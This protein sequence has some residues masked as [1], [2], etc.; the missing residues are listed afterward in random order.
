MS[1][2]LSFLGFGDNQ[3][4]ADQKKSFKQNMEKTYSKISKALKTKKN[5]KHVE[6]FLKHI[7]SK[8]IV[9]TK[10]E[11]AK[12]DFQDFLQ[13][14]VYK[15][16]S[17]F[18]SALS[19]RGSKILVEVTRNE[20]HRFLSNQEI[21]DRFE[22]ALEDMNKPPKKFLPSFDA[23]MKMA[24]ENSLQERVPKLN[25]KEADLPTGIMNTGNSC[26]SSAMLQVLFNYPDFVKAI[27]GF[28]YD[29]IKSVKTHVKPIK[30]LEDSV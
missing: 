6:T 23:Q 24:M 29:E 27:C 7:K 30:I 22:K 5:K 21:K 2:F 3:E 28:R 12:E 4:K 26:Y 16:Y 9:Y 13:K 14:P 25:K 18:L 20:K 8:G 19:K 11:P 15:K 1:D 10:M 17:N